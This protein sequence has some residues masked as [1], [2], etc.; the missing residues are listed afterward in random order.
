MR[1]LWRGKCRWMHRTR[2]H[3]SVDGVLRKVGRSRF[4]RRAIWAAADFMLG[5]DVHRSRDGQRRLG[6]Q[7]SS[8]LS[9]RAAQICRKRRL[10][11][12]HEIAA[13]R[14]STPAGRA[15]VKR[16]LGGNSSVGTHL[17][18]SD[19]QSG[20]SEDVVL[21]GDQHSRRT[22]CWWKRMRRSWRRCPTAA[23]AT[24]R[25]TSCTRQRPSRR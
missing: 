15:S 12:A 14:L 22:A 4:W 25:P 1:F 7:R 5:V 17:P 11:R 19:A 23:S 24:S 8:H 2:P 18:S 3:L 13:P 20:I 16:G 6:V 9:F 10:A 21:G